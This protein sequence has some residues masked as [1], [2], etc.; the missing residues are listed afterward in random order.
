MSLPVAAI[1]IRFLI[2]FIRLLIIFI[3]FLISFPFRVKG[4]RRAVERELALRT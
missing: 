1:P 4:K 3:R 2:I